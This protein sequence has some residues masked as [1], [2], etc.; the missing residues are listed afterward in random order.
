MQ[1]ENITLLPDAYY[2]GEDGNN[3][4]LLRLN[5]LAAED[6]SDLINDVDESL[7]LSLATGKTLDLYGEL[8]GQKRGVLNDEQYRLLILNK[9]GKNLCQ[10]DYKNTVELIAQMFGCDKS[11][12]AIAD[13]SDNLKVTL[14]K[15]PLHVLIDAGFSGEQAVTIIEMLLPV[16]VKLT[17]IN[18]QGTFEFGADAV[19]YKM[20]E[21]RT[22]NK[23]EELTYEEI[24]DN[25]Y[26]EDKG[27]S[28]SYI[29][30]TEE[31]IGGDL[32]LSIEDS[33]FDLPI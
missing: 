3:F 5:E 12:I 4:K 7:D 2:K 28:E 20:L 17:A 16:C 29:Y 8:V 1:K 25:E 23:L 33:T 31:G 14:T 10:A 18:F 30:Y 9:I 24:E 22:Y 6:L 21:N 15:F 11:E 19:T 26:D 32:G 27:F 13:S